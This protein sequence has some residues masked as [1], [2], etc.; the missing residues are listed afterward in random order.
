[1]NKMKYIM[2]LGV[3]ILAVGCSKFSMHRVD[4]YQGNYIEQQR[5]ENLKPGMT[6]SDVQLLLGT[7]LVQDV[8]D[9]SVW[10]YVF[11]HSNSEGKVKEAKQVR[12]H[13]DR[14]GRYQFFDGDIDLNAPQED[15][16]VESV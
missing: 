14:D 10:Y 3:A 16:I 1:M 6:R 11:F 2:L 9:P 15:I 5:L 7:P 4:V 12:V 13:F 8:Y